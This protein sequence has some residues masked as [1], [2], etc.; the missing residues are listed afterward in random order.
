MIRG[1]SSKLHLF[2]VL[3]LL[4]RVSL[5]S[6]PFIH[7]TGGYIPDKLLWFAFLWIGIALRGSSSVESRRDPP[8]VSVTRFLV[9]FRR[10]VFSFTSHLIEYWDF[11]MWIDKGGYQIFHHAKLFLW[12]KKVHVLY[13]YRLHSSHANLPRRLNLF[14]CKMR[15]LKL[16]LLM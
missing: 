7:R 8:S 1:P 13:S 2:K 3:T 14:R 11:S 15:S 9:L 16:K 6:R 4:S 12:E 5:E 10:T